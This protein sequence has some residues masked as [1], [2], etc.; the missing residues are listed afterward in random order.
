MSRQCEI[1]GMLAHQ[2]TADV[3]FDRYAPRNEP[4]SAEEM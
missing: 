3:R 1:E 4:T 2:I